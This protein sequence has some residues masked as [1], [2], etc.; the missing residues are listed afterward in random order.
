MVAA[1]VGGRQALDHLGGGE[2]L[3]E[4]RE[5]VGP[6]TR[7]RVRL[8]RDRADAGPRP[9]DDRADGEELR[10]RRDAPLPGVEVAGGDRVGRDDGLHR[11]QSSSIVSPGSSSRMVAFG[12]ST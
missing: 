3:R 1:V 8:R 6:V 11:S 2:A 5:P 4:Q 10:L 12:A 9:R 7:V